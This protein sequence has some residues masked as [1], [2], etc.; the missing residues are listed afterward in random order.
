MRAIVMTEFGGPEVLQEQDWPKPEAKTGE[1]LVRVHAASV[2]PVDYKIRTSGRW[3]RVE[4]PWILGY[5]VS[6]VV[7][8]VG[9]GV[10]DFRVG[11]DV[12]YSPEIFGLQ[13]CNGEYHVAHESIVVHKPANLSHVEAAGIP[14]AGGTSWDALFTRA[15]LRVGE[16]ILIHAGA[17][18]C[19][20]FAIQMAKAAGA[21]V[22]T[23]CG[24]YNV[25]LVTQL[26]ADRAIDY[27]AEDFVKVCKED[28][29]GTGVDVVYDTVGGDNIAKSVEAVRREGRIVTI[30]PTATDLGKAFMKNVTLHFLFMQRARYKLEGMKDL[31]ER[32]LLK[33]VIDSILPLSDVAKAHEKLEAGGVRGKIVL[34]VMKE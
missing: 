9:H 8:A 6:G 10:K 30:L 22:F 33:P 24:A 14:L 11:D 21:Y 13:G 32:G 31:I 5:D 34:E 26:G 28:T 19:G 25:D 7:E 16:R 27:R 2:N 18:G 23:T 29:G 20:A 17:G 3:A 4:P 12:F 1:L 15:Q